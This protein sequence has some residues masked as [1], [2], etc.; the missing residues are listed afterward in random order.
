MTSNFTEFN[1][2]LDLSS[3]FLLLILH[4]LSFNDYTYSALTQ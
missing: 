1:F 3:G 2:V 4:M